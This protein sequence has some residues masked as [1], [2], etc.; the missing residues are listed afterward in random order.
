MYGMFRKTTIYLPDDLKAGVE[1]EAKRRGC[2]EAEVIR[3]A[4]ASALSRP[5][6][7]AALIDGEPVAERVDELL[8]GFGE[9]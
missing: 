8:A 9:R 3:A 1:R 7:R 4:V 2:S 5:R 6:P